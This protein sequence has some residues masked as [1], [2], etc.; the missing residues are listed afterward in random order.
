[1]ERKEF[2]KKHR[3]GDGS[4][5]KVGVAVSRFNG[6]ITEALLEGALETLRT[7]NV[8][9]KNIHVM[10]VAGSFELPLAAQRLIQKHKADAVVAL[11]CIVK[12][13][14]KHDEYIAHAVFHGLA[15][16]SLDHAVPVGLGVLTVNTLPQARARSR[17][18][19][20][21][22]AYAAAAALDSALA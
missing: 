18:K 9:E 5:L 22:G 1:M 14:T 20:N 19:T 3:P 13:E 15:R 12:G 8:S 6:D 21:H 2:A 10:H 17:G 7:W 16:V 11:G 4:R